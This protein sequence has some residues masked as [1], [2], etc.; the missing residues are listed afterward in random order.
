MNIN[1]TFKNFEPS[2]HLKKYAQRRFEKISKYVGGKGDNSELNINLS[3][4]KYRHR[5]EVVFIGDKLHIS[6]NESSEDMYSSID[7]VLDKL[8]AQVRKNR[9]KTKDKRKGAKGRV[10]PVQTQ[11]FQYS[12]SGDGTR[13]RKIVESDN[14]E[15][16]PMDVDEAAEQLDNLNCDFLVFQNSETD[17]VNVIYRRKNNDFGLIDP[18]T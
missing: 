6:A 7:L 16:K 14:F 9:E 13:E 10:N 15:P 12:E 3:V 4:D 1:F 17:R 11:F 8:E 5:A 2:E 18:G